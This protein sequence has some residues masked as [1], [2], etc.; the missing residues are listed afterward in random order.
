VSLKKKWVLTQEAFNRLLASLDA[1][2]EQA[3]QK[4]ERIRLKL[5]HYFAWR[6]TTFPE[7]EA[8]ETINRVAQKIEAGEEIKNLNAYFYGVARLVFAESLRIR[9]REQEAIKQAPLAEVSFKD[10]DSDSA[11]RRVCLAN[12]L[13]HLPEESRDLIIEYYQDEQGKKIKRRK[14][15][16]SRLDIPVNA[17]RIRAHRIRT[18]LEMCVKECLGK[19]A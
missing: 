3:G 6:G 10:Y 5:I 11:R 12:C 17:L 2:C 4:Y 18:G 9:E 19:Q 8:D 14:D 15:L 7:A 13:R 16:A 1:D